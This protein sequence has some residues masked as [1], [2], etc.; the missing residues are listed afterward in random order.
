MTIQ[1]AAIAVAWMPGAPDGK[2]TTLNR[3]L[4]RLWRWFTPQRLV[5]L[6]GFAVIAAGIVCLYLS[7]AAAHPGSWWQATLDAFGVGLVVGGLINLLAIS[8]LNQI[9]TRAQTDLL[10]KLGIPAPGQII[11]LEP[12]R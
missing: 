5:F 6:A 9:L 8:G 4:G 7:D 12:A 2:P 1:A 3:V 11:E 10:A